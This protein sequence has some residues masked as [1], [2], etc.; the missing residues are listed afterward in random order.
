MIYEALFFRVINIGYRKGC[1]NRSGFICLNFKQ[2]GGSLLLRF[3]YVVVPVKNN[4]LICFIPGEI[5][6]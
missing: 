6:L 3:Q 2:H 1:K 5:T 4:I